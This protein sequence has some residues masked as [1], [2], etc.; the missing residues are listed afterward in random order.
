MSQIEINWL[1]TDSTPPRGADVTHQAPSDSA[2]IGGYWLCPSESD[3]RESR[4]GRGQDQEAPLSQPEEAAPIQEDRLWRVQED[5]I[6]GSLKNLRGAEWCYQEDRD[7][8]KRS[9]WFKRRGKH[10]FKRTSWQLNN[11]RGTRGSFKRFK[12][13]E[14]EGLF[15]QEERDKHHFKRTPWQLNNLRGT[16]DYWFKR[17]AKQCFKSTRRLAPDAKRNEVRFQEAPM[18]QFGEDLLIQEDDL[19]RFQEVLRT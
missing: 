15:I 6:V 8:W 9:Y 7:R 12:E 5:S 18:G 3:R 2:R 16:R 1:S 13:S 11:Q 17:R 10:R 4:G 19:R 14:L